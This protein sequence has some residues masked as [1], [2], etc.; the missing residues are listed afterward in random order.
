MRPMS[1][2]LFVTTGTVAA[3]CIAAGPPTQAVAAQGTGSPARA[4]AQH[5]PAHPIAFGSGDPA[6]TISFTVTSGAQTLSVPASASLGSGGAGNNTA[7]WN[8]AISVAVPASAVAGTYT[9]TLTQS[10]A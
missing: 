4:Q 9:G 2:I 3:A 5:A 6:A 1:L 10:V 8:H 7:S